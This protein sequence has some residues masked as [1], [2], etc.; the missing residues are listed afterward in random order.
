[1]NTHQKLHMNKNKLF[2]VCS[3]L[4]LI[5]F[6]RPYFLYA[7][8]VTSPPVDVSVS[9]RVGSDIAVD[10]GGSGGGYILPSG[11]TFSGVTTPSSTVFILQDG[12]VVSAVISDPNG[13]FF[14]SIS[15]L[16]PISYIF[17]LYSEDTYGV[18]SEA[19]SFPLLI[20]LGT[21]ITIT[22]IVLATPRVSLQEVPV[23]S[24]PK[25][26]IKENIGDQSCP[27]LRADLNCDRHVNMVDFSILVHWY[28]K[29]N[30][31]KI[32]DLNH[33]SRITLAD[34]SIMAYNWTD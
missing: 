32:L 26:L 11:V 6:F 27:S 7:D 25:T 16:F 15:Q 29:S 10:G 19:V 30:P 28:K 34:F 18:K 24:V 31:P 21:T 8:T 23:P 14:V 33:D 17:S 5:I 9:A 4:L 13:Y 12:H 20:K 3:V 1:M 2:Y 22:N